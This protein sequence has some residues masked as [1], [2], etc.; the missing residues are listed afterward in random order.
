MVTYKKLSLVSILQKTKDFESSVHNPSVYF[1]Y[2]PFKA[3]FYSYWPLVWNFF[4]IFC[5]LCLKHI[6]VWPSQPLSLLLRTMWLRR[7]TQSKARYAAPSSTKCITL[8]RLDGYDLPRRMWLSITSAF[9]C[10]WLYVC[11]SATVGSTN[12]CFFSFDHF[13]MFGCFISLAYGLHR[14]QCGS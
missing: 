13:C 9:C 2:F 1:D 8:I 3:E 11:A 4:D 5:S 12:P 10:S 14:Q 6:L 7:N